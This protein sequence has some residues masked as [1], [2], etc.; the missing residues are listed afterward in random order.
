MN[1]NKL[2]SCIVLETWVHL[3]KP[4]LLKLGQSHIVYITKPDQNHP[5]DMFNKYVVKRAHPYNQYIFNL[6][7]FSL[8]LHIKYK[9]ISIS[10]P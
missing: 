7:N 9:F 10:F 8:I 2:I 6:Y 1:A 5:L 4:P 3:K